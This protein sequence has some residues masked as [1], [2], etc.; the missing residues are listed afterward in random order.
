MFALLVEN[1][2]PKERSAVAELD[3]E[4]S[5]CLAQTRYSFGKARKGDASA[6]MHK[7]SKI[8]AL[9]KNAPGE[10]VT[11]LALRST[12]RVVQDR[13]RNYVTKYV[14]AAQEITDL[15]VIEAGFKV[16]TREVRQEPRRT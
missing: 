16:G 15:Q 4:H 10:Q 13:I 5:G 9:L 1:L 12:Q 6:S 8:Y 11:Y 14:P 2:P 3:S 7:A